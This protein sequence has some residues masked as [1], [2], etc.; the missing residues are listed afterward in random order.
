MKYQ[1]TTPCDACP[2]LRKNAKNYRKGRLVGF[3]ANEF[4]CHNT[5][6]LREDEEGDAERLRCWSR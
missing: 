5:A 2:F 3:A 1:M 6:D 4:P